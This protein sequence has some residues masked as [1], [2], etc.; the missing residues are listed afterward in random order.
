MNSHKG[1][2]VYDYPH[3]AVSADIV[4]LR[5]VPGGMQIALVRRGKDPFRGM[6]AVPGGFMNIEETL[7][8]AARRELAEETGLRAR[9]VEQ[10]Y[11]FDEPQRDPRG[12]TLSVAFLALVDGDQEGRAGDDAGEFAWFPS[13]RL[14]ELAF[15]HARIIAKGLKV[16]SQWQQ[17]NLIERQ[18]SKQGSGE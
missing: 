9:F 14:P 10:F 5:S 2:Y 12:R 4:C 7:L 11:C 13:D 16:L 3:P 17:L 8:S 6:W 15:D 1:R 18:V